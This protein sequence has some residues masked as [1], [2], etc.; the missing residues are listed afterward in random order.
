M[1]V[2]VIELLQM[3]NFGIRTAG[4]PPE[5]IKVTRGAFHI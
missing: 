3:K 1:F 4:S 5:T 2:N